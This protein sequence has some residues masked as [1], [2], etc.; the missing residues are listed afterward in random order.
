MADFSHSREGHGPYYVMRVP[1]ISYSNLLV[2][3]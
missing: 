1:I 2:D 3:D